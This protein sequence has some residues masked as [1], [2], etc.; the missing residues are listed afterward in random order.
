MSLGV[1]RLKTVSFGTYIGGLS[2]HPK[3]FRKF[4]EELIYV[5]YF[6]IRGRTSTSI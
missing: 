6:W 2:F 3:W 1:R 5:M 4:E